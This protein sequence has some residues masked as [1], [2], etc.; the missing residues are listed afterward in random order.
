[1]DSSDIVRLISTFI[2]ILLSMF[3]SS[4]ETAM[5]SS[6]K[7]HMRS[8]SED[9]NIRAARV[10]SLSSDTSKLLSM[11][12]IGNNIVNL[13][14]SALVTSVAINVWGNYAVGIATGIL[15]F[16]VLIF[17][18]ILPKTIATIYADNIALAYSG[19]LLVL[20]RLMTPLIF[21][22]N[23]FSDGI[24]F[25]LGIDKNAKTDV[26]TEEDLRTIIDVGQEEGVLEQ[27]EH[28]MIHNVVDFGDS[29][30]KD[31]M[32]PRIDMDCID[33]DDSFDELIALF[34]STKYTRIPVFEESKDH[35][36]GIVHI[37]DV[38]F[39]QE[40]THPSIRELMREPVFTFEYKKVSELL[41][42]MRRDSISLVIVLD[43]YGD[44]AGLITIED[45]I[46]EI[47]GDIKDE[48]DEDETAQYQMLSPDLYLIQGSMK[49]EDV[50]D[51]LGKN[52]ESDEYDSLAGYVISLAQDL[53]EVGESFQSD[54]LMFTVKSID[55]NRIDQIEVQILPETN[56]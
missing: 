26:M 29:L 37:K 6:N 31:V 1:M 5:T 44:T 55:N 8:L 13:T 20:M 7:L 47:V 42:E 17:A 11:I 19:I 32:I 49:L 43:E 27:E 56:P 54:H 18:E 53:P 34:R 33:V 51:L 14:A 2:L 25:L 23:G 16:I 40:D 38:F 30:A 46:E 22:I 28:Q 50:G 4:A 3:F 41:S 24:L 36:I 9:G 35:I 10:L 12:L 45:L 15:T 39:L 21:L 52:L 48:Y